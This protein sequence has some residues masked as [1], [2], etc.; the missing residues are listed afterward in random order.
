M[1]PTAEQLRHVVIGTGVHFVMANGQCRPARLVRVY[2]PTSDE[3]LAD[4]VVDF[5]KAD[6]GVEPFNHESSTGGREGVKFSRRRADGA[7][8]PGTWHHIPSVKA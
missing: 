6:I 3:G 4:L 5:C 7:G 2:D 1:P 8:I